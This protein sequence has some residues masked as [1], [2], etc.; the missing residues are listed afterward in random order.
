MAYGRHEVRVTLQCSYY[1]TVVGDDEDPQFGTLVRREMDRGEHWGYE[2]AG[3]AMSDGGQ[4]AGWVR[5]GWAEDEVDEDA[6][7]FI[8][9]G[10]ALWEQ[11]RDAD[12]YNK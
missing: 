3:E 8:E 7:D 1:L 10:L 2:G 6:D 11:R 12:D 4:I 9:G 5:T